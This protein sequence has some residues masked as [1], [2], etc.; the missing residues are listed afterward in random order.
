M[1]ETGAELA[2][3]AL[4]VGF[5]LRCTEKPWGS[6]RWA[7]FYPEDVGDRIPFWPPQGRLQRAGQ[8][9]GIGCF[10]RELGKF[11]EGSGGIMCPLGTFCPLQRNICVSQK[12]RLPLLQQE[13]ELL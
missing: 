4:V 2:V 7:R 6:L 9:A 5:L 12:R 11:R 10:S 13:S 8:G 3:Q 1:L